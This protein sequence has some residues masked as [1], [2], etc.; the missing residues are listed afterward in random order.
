AEAEQIDIESARLG[1]L[2]GREHDMAHAHLAHLEEGNA[3]RRG[4][5][6][7]VNDVA[8]AQL[9]A[10]ARR[11]LAADEFADE[12]VSRLRSACRLKR[13]ARSAQLGQACIVID[14]RTIDQ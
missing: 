6:L 5:G 4:E 10:V 11:I 8:P 1:K 3:R 7:A 2:D 13:D 14:L 12:A 9:E